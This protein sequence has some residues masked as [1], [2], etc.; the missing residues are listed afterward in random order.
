MAFW[1]RNGRNQHEATVKSGELAHKYCN[2]KVEKT[3]TDARTGCKCAGSRLWGEGDRSGRG[4][5]SERFIN[6]P[7]AV[8]TSCGIILWMVKETHNLLVI[9][10]FRN[11]ISLLLQQG[12]LDEGS[13]LGRVCAV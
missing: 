3:D 12:I 1:C 2:R 7:S 9:K 11:S 5:G 4:H 6:N 13:G 8:G 10:L